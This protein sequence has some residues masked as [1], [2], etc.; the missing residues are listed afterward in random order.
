MVDA[1]WIHLWHIEVKVCMGNPLQSYSAS[2]AIWDHTVLPAMHHMWTCLTL[3]LARQAITHFIYPEGWNAELVLVI[4]LDV[5]PVC[6]QLPNSDDTLISFRCLFL[7]PIN[8][9]RKLV[10]P[11]YFSGARNWRRIEHVLTIFGTTIPGKT[12]HQ[13]INQVSA[14]L[15]ICFCTTWVN[16]NTWNWH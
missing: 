11:S 15:N 1:P 12:C 7:V 9:Y 14:S 5:L 10:S 2:P 13:M 8:W 3:T 6:R 4:C 16:Q